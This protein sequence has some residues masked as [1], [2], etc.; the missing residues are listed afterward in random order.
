MLITPETIRRLP[1]RDRILPYDEMG[2]VIRRLK[3]RAPIFLAQGVFDMMHVGHAGYLRA[4]RSIEPQNGIVVVGI[5]SDQ[6][7][8]HNKGN[9][10]PVNTES[11]RADLLSEFRSADLVFVYSGV[12]DYN[13]PDD[14][15]DRYRHLS[16]TAVVV[17]TWDPHLGLKETQA[18]RS[19]TSIAQVVYRHENS[20]TRMLTKIGYE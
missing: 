4:A 3:D 16:P 12:P 17:P 15:I 14:F 10:R 8:Q 20:T 2:Q 19:G 11:E 7:V 18:A 9:K 13:N 5:E 1:Q 6:S